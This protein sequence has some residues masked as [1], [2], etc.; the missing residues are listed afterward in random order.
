MEKL[1]DYLVGARS[2]A[3]I[4]CHWR[5]FWRTC[6]GRMIWRCGSTWVSFKHWWSRCQL[7]ENKKPNGN[8]QTADSHKYYMDD[9]FLQELAKLWMVKNLCKSVKYPSLRTFRKYCTSSF[10]RK[11]CRD[12]Y[13]S[14]YLSFSY[15]ILYVKSQVTEHT[16]VNSIRISLL[17]ACNFCHLLLRLFL[18]SCAHLHDQEVIPSRTTKKDL[19][20]HMLG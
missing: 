5:A 11:I 1:V 8:F 18:R 2:K 13:R 17:Q 12:Q 7:Q 19:L 9:I 20:H 6:K 4:R 14:S 15:I 10:L 16:L 3:W